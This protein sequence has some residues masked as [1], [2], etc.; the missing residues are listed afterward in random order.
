MNRI[1]EWVKEAIGKGY[2]YEIYVENRKKK[3]VETANEKLENILKAQE[4]GVGIR[5]FKNKRMGFSYTTE[6][7]EE[8]IKECVRKAVEVCELTPED[9]GFELRAHKNYGE[10]ETYY[11]PEGLS[12]SLD[13]RIELLIGLERKAKAR[14]GRIKGVRKVSL[15]ETELEVSCINSLGLEY[16]YRGTWFSTLMAVVAEEETDNS[17]SYSYAGSRRLS[18]LPFDNMLEEAIFKATAVLKPDALEPTLMPVVLFREASAMLL[19]AFS[20]IFLGDALIKGK[21][22]LKGMEGQRVFSEKLSIIDDGLLSEG[23]MSLPVDVEGNPTNTFS[24]VDKGIFKGFLHNTYTGIKSGQ[25]STGN[26]IRESFRSLPNVGIRNLYIE[27]GTRSFEELISLEERVF[28]ATD[29]MGLHTVDPV[30]GDFS[31]GVSGIIYRG[32]RV[33]KRVRGAVMAGNIKKVWGSVVEVGKDLRFYANVGSPSILIE[34][35]T[36]GG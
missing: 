12:L 19:E 32:G 16:S 9:E 6:L 20:P 4:A 29:L 26:A 18:R 5:V 25:A 15:K 30:S 8:A 33:E 36:L 13:D 24:L 22:F 1:E 7:K 28:L 27:A 17:I 3:T 14:D 21:T 34:A 2:E 35:I 10:L 11:D 31:L 23:F